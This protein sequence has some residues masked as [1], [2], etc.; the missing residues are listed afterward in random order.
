MAKDYL[1]QIEDGTNTYAIAST[2]YGVCNTNSN[3]SNKIVSCENFTELIN[4][5]TIKVKFTYNNTAN[6]P[7][8]NVNNTGKKALYRYGTTAPGTKDSEAWYAGS[9]LSITYD[10]SAWVIN[11]YKNDTNDNTWIPNALNR[12]G[13][14]A[15]PTSTEANRVWET[16]DNGNPSWKDPNL[17]YLSTSESLYTAINNAGWTSEV[18]E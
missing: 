10:G 11:D 17:L 15:A 9:V 18:I 14:V 5:V 12:A 7:T 3:D 1:G 13:Y 16:D 8:I 4:G 6:N 2:L